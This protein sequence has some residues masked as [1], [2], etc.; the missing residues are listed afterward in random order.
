MARADNLKKHQINKVTYN[1]QLIID[2][3]N[4]INKFGGEIS[5]STVAAMSKNIELSRGTKG[6]GLTPQA[7]YKNQEY[8]NLVLQEMLLTDKAKYESFKGNTKKS[9]LDEADLRMENF[10]LKHKIILLEREVKQLKNIMLHFGESKSTNN[11]ESK[12][13]EID[14]HNIKKVTKVV[15]KDM[16]IIL[17][18]LKL[19]KLL[20]I[21]K[22]TKNLKLVMH[23]DLL[24]E[25]KSAVAYYG[26]EF[27]NEL[28]NIQESYVF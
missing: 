13:N 18:T 10:E 2:S 15:K 4:E 7:I 17:K 27:L 14:I 25:H 20:E 5:V 8:K 3:V 6:G 16:E 12:S 11:I 26:E 28:S 21:D 1:K 22:V 23:G 19:R 24:L 9:M